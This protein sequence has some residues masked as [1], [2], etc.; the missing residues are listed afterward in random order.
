MIIV[1]IEMSPRQRHDVIGSNDGRRPSQPNEKIRNV[2]DVTQALEAMA[3]CLVKALV[4]IRGEGTPSGGKG[5]FS[6]EFYKHPFLMV[7]GNLDSGEVREW[8]TN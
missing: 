6:K 1:T 8:L 3:S 7:K 5:C 4:N 2:L